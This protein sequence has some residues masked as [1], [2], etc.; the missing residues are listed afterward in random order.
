MIRG[1]G[2]TT[3][4]PKGDIMA[5]LSD[6]IKKHF[7]VD[8]RYNPNP[9]TTTVGTTPTE[10]WRNNPDRI[11]LLFINLGATSVYLNVDAN[12]SS[13]NGIFLAA[14]GGSVILLAEED[15]ELVGFPWYGISSANC[16]IFSAEIEGK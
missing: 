2:Q 12:V 10:L 1:F 14:G 3:P 6:Y 13:T 11:T 4:L 5:V 9:I 7:D 8:T 16:V 15:G